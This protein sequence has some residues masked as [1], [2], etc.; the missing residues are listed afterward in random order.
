M[1]GS[2]E[3]TQRPSQIREEPQMKMEPFYLVFEMQSEGPCEYPSSDACTLIARGEWN[4][5]HSSRHLASRLPAPSVSLHRVLI[6]AGV[7]SG[8]NDEPRR[9]SLSL[10]LPAADES[11]ARWQCEIIPA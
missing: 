7:T 3:R 4:H 1:N 5:F 2:I 9:R 6:F 8:S 11:S 10:D